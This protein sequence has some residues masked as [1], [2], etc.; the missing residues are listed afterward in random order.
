MPS[1]VAW[2]HTHGKRPNTVTAYEREC[3]GIV[4]LKWYDNR[5]TR[6]RSLGFRVRRPDGKLLKRSVMEAKA[7]AKERHQILAGHRDEPE[8]DSLTLESG[9]EMFFT[10]VTGRFSILKRDVRENAPRL[11]RLVLDV[12]GPSTRWGE[13]RGP[14]VTTKL[15]RTL[16]KRCVSCFL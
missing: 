5:K 4:Y 11:T 6:K 12:L 7:Q 9:Y 1:K 10:P 15:I 3:G 13:L 16:A 8:P 2:M 14:S